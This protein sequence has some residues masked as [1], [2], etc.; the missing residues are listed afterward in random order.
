MGALVKKVEIYTTPICPYCH[1]AKSL[2]DS[3]QIAY[4][5]IE[6]GM[7][8][9]RRQ[10]ME[11]RAGGQSTVPQIFIADKHIGGCTELYALDENGQLDTLLS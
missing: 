5:E 11:A 2:L 7:D 10:Q 9:Q 4:V 3:K 6:V 1:A 8:T